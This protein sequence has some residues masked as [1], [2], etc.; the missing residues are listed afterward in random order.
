[1]FQTFVQRRFNAVFILAALLIFPIAT[2]AEVRVAVVNAE[3]EMEI[4]ADLLSVELSK[5]GDLALLERAQLSR[6]AAERKLSLQQ[7]N[8]ALQ[9]GGLLGA[10]GV[11]LMQS[12]G[13]RTNRMAT[14]RFVA[15]REGVALFSMRMAWPPASVEEWATKIARKT[16]EAAPKTTADLNTARRL[17]IL[18]LRAASR[19]TPEQ[20]LERELTAALLARLA[21]EPNLFVTE[22]Q[23]LGD[24][25]FEK[26]LAAST[27]KFWTGS[28]LLDGT[29]NEKFAP[30]RVN[31]SARLHSPDGSFVKIDVE[32][33]RAETSKVI[34]SLAAKILLALKVEPKAHW[35]AAREANELVE[36]A[37]WAARWGMWREAQSAGD[38]AWALGA[39]TPD[40]AAARALAYARETK[41]NPFYFPWL[42]NDRRRRRDVTATSGGRSIPVHEVDTLVLQ[43]PAAFEAENALRALAAVEDGL[44]SDANSLTNA[45]WLQSITEI[46]EH[47]G[48]VLCHYYL[49]PRERAG[50]EE[51]LAEIR[52]VGR[53]VA[54]IVLA[55][56]SVRTN[57]WF[58]SADTRSADSVDEYFRNRNFFSIYARY[59]AIFSD[60]PEQTVEAVRALLSA[61]GFPYV[62]AEF[63]KMGAALGTWNTNDAR[64]AAR[65][66]KDFTRELQLSRN[67]INQ[68]N[69]KI[70]G[71]LLART[72][73]DIEIG[74]SDLARFVEA[75]FEQLAS[76][77]DELKVDFFTADGII[78]KFQE[79]RNPI[80]ITLDTKLRAKRQQLFIDASVES[81]GRKL[82]M[83]ITKAAMVAR[84]DPQPKPATERWPLTVV[85]DISVD[86]PIIVRDYW[87]SA[88]V[89][90][91]DREAIRRTLLVGPIVREG[92][93]WVQR[94][95]LAFRS[96]GLSWE[97]VLA[98]VDCETLQVLETLRLE[99]RESI[100][101]RPDGEGRHP[102][103]VI[104]GEVFVTGQNVL[105]KRSRDSRNWTRFPSPERGG[106]LWAIGNRLFLTSADSIYEVNPATGEARTLASARR[107]PS[108]GILDALPNWTP[109]ILTK[110]PNGI[111]AIIS[112]SV[113]VFDGAQWN[114]ETAFKNYSAQVAGSDI[115]FCNRFMREPG[116]FLALPPEATAAISLAETEDCDSNPWPHRNWAFSRASFEQSRG[117]RLK[118]NCALLS[119]RSSAY[120][121]QKDAPT[122]GESDLF[123]FVGESK[124]PVQIPIQ[125]EPGRN[126]FAAVPDAGLPWEFIACT[127]KHIWLRNKKNP[128]IWRLPLSEVEERLKAAPQKTAQ[129]STARF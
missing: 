122:R 60:S 4:A 65:V 88:S 50:V 56:P 72:P 121:S 42:Q 101:T 73:E 21:Q 54:A 68:L 19:S 94:G 5:S 85:Q 79:N 17:S 129:L 70:F 69:G 95:D 78:Y 106:D 114:A 26:D 115:F 93:L 76:G 110:G 57:L 91:E 113:Y 52:R 112:A 23:K 120:L 28:H 27:E 66:W 13:E 55:N 63:L 77:H 31:V 127:D 84:N 14:V 103:E 30:G 126:R 89:G 105:F 16:V 45:A 11:L 61:D 37:K 1:M 44:M 53:S 20:A 128:G 119:F 80:F 83:D 8:G 118:T 3:P 15:V 33:P 125:F 38:A 81:G 107:R 71:S 36:E 108:Q 22:R 6:I 40:A 18:N 58:A 12:S 97:S 35:D 62:R 43:T 102:H 123:V 109:P 67:V 104:N 2:R 98:R 116:Q 24:L 59:L 34:E 90:A 111:R 87:D 25:A 29:I 99:E 7:V 46:M 51:P 82:D 47:S 92:S 100:A 49:L 9:A 48:D 75:H 96:G 74:T 117:F 86:H 41:L 10:N 124:E 32:G 64:R 39:R